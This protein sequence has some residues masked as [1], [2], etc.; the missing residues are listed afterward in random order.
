MAKDTRSN[1]LK[2]EDN[3]LRSIMNDPQ[4]QQLL[5]CLKPA[6]DA[7]AAIAKGKSCK[8]CK[9]AKKDGVA[10]AMNQA[11]RCVANTRGKSLRE[12]KAALNTKQLRILAKNSSGKTIQWTL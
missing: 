7:L 2:I 3:T 1:I 8:S 4:L 9:S 12:L 6:A 10:A 5:P 11:R